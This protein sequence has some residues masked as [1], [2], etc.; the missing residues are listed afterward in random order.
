MKPIERILAAV[1][2]SESS[3]VAFKAAIGLAKL[4]SAELHVVHVFDTPMPH[5]SPYSLTI[6]PSF[7]SKAR[8]AA[9]RKLEKSCQMATAAGVR[10]EY[11]LGT[12]PTVRPIVDLARQ[13]ESEL[14]KVRN[15]GKTSLREIK[16]KLS[17]LDLSL[18]M[19][20]DE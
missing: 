4:L 17:D 20:L 18:G 3:N 14:L 1:D 15:F 5:F 9:A 13:T 2:F 16:K 7:I 19:E 6:P 10:A 11:H 12:A 8:D